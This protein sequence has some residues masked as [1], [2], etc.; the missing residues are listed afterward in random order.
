MNSMVQDTKT[1]AKC[2]RPEKFT[3]DQVLTLSWRE[4]QSVHNENGTHRV[5]VIWSLDHYRIRVY[6]RVQEPELFIRQHTAKYARTA[7]TTA[8]RMLRRYKEAL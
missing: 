1:T 3:L 5:E 7:C 6:R 8:N 2:L 4:V